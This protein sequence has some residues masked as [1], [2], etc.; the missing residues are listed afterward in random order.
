MKKITRRTLLRTGLVSGLALTAGSGYTATHH[1]ELIRRDVPI[2][3]LDGSL[4]GLTVG[5]LS[6][7]H[8]GGGSLSPED[9]TTAV[10]TVNAQRP[11]LV[12][13]L[14]DFVD[15]GPVDP[16]IRN[17][18]FTSLGRLKAPLGVY[19]V[20]GNHDQWQS[21][22][23]VRKELRR[24]SITLLNNCSRQV[25]PGLVLAGI[26][27]YQWGHPDLGLALKEIPDGPSA[28]LL[29]HNPDINQ[30]LRDERVKLVLSGHTHGGQIRIPGVDWAPWVH[31]APKYHGP[32][33]LIREGPHRWTFLTKGVGTRL[34]PIR[35]ACPPDVA[36]L[37][38]R[39]V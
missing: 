5:V 34:L 20:L 38:L 36:V 10:A 25:A 30:E 17:F 22:A 35:I 28:I 8:A 21:P 39:R 31:C 23:A 19:A 27:D 26:D 1:L 29:S 32:G 3:G 18:L 9:V 15:E 24:E 33:G 11:H 6:D 7:F 12:T 4:D 13:L 37:T 14:G 16:E 2:A